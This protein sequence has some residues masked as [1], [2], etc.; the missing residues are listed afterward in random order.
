MLPFRPEANWL[1]CQWKGTIPRKAWRRVLFNTIL[2]SVMLGLVRFFSRPTWELFEVPDPTH[3]LIAHL[4]AWGT[5]WNYQLTLTTFVLT[6]FLN[7]AYTFWRGCLSLAR[8]IQGRFNDIGFLLATHAMRRK[9]GRYTEASASLLRDVGRYIRLM[10]VLYWA[11]IVRLPDVDDPERAGLNQLLCPEGLEALCRQGAL[12]P[13]ERSLLLARGPLS[14]SYCVVLEWIMVRCGE[15]IH[16]HTLKGGQVHRQLA[17]LCV[18]L[19]AT[20]ATIPDNHETRMP[21]AYMHFVQVLVDSLVLQAPFALYPAVGAYSVLLSALLTLFYT[22]LAEM[23]KGFLDPFAREEASDDLL[24]VDVLIAETNRGS[25]RW[26]HGASELP[27][28]VLPAKL[29][30]D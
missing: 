22:G 5:M 23:S 27:P 28:A 3:T 12:T 8:K 30:V 20:C 11:S 2:A 25:L 19:R 14:A 13:E 18:Q 9:D 6:F 26:F 7:Q 29:T 10:H 17:G 24:H 15:A 21:L 16:D 4:R 1:W